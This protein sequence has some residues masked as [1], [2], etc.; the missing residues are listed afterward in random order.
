MDDANKLPLVKSALARDGASSFGE[1]DRVAI[2]VY[3]GA[4]GLVLPS[5]SCSEKAK[6][7]AAIDHLQAGGSTNGG[8]G[9]Q[10]AYAQAAAELHQ[11]RG[12]PR[13]PRHR[14]RFQ[15]RRDQPGRPHPPDR[16]Q[17]QE[18]RLPHRARLRH[19]QPQGRRR[20]RQLADKGNG[21]YAYID[22]LGEARKVLV[23]ELG[24]TL[25][26][27]AKDVKIQ[28][29]FNPARVGGLPPDR[30]REPRPGKQDFNDDK[31]DA[32]EIGAGHTSRRSTSW[33]P[34][35]RNGG[36]PA[37]TRSS[38]RRAAPEAAAAETLVVKLR[39]KRPTGTRAGRSRWASTTG[40][41]LLARLRR[42]QVRLGGRRLRDAAAPLPAARGA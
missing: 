37:S 33:S 42:P 13:D 20:W 1:N 34:R 10:L 8:A 32:G 7:L 24:G 18:R 27:I 2:V 17:G 22:S 41:G 39:Y 26:T 40:P 11:G 6:I 5:T 30:L 21:H 28:V 4:P 31:K 23:E 19:G 16:G 12:E 35:A 9:I 29:E 25:V 38:S 15:R 36:C 3:A 14:R